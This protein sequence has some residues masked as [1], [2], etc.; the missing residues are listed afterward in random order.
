MARLKRT[1]LTVLGWVLVLAGVAALVLPGPGLLLLC[2]GLVVLSQE[3]EWAARR[4][5]PV[6]EAAF[7][8]AS[9]GV[10]TWPRILLSCLGVL[11]LFACGVLWLLQP[12]APGWWPVDQ[13]W[14]LLGGWPTGLTL[15]FSGLIALGLL[16]YSVRRFRSNPY[17]GDR[18]AS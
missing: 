18:G 13:R 11:G 6:R 2:V 17:Q 4:V 12:A 7:R 8:T 9:D 15:V 16:V 10:Q 1:L 14:W 5:E 3:Y